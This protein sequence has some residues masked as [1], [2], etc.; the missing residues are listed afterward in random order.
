M[1]KKQCRWCRIEKEAT[2]ENFR[3]MNLNKDWLHEACKVCEQEIEDKNKRLEQ[4]YIETLSATKWDYD[5]APMSGY[6]DW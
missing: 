2:P 5:D 4:R 1:K 6:H 3:E